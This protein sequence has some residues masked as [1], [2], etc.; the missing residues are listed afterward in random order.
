M[1]AGFDHRHD[2]GVVEPA[3]QVGFTLQA[4]QPFLALDRGQ[5]D[6]QADELDGDDVAGAQ[7]NRFAH[8]GRGALAQ[9]RAQA[10]AASQQGRPIVDVQSG[11]CTRGAA[12]KGKPSH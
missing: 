10:V 5:V 1:Q 11:C 12:P 8:L 4:L 6:R 9:P 3:R 2:V 7:V